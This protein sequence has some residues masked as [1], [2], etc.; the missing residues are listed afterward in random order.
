MYFVLKSLTFFT[1]FLSTCFGHTTNQAPH[2][3]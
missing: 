1:L 3:M 2:G